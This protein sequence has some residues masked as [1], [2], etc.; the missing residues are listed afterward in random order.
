MEPDP[1]LRT[2]QPVTPAPEIEKALL[3]AVSAM[4]GHFRYESGHHGDLWLNLDELFLD[5]RSMRSWVSA[6]AQQAI[7]CRPQFVCGP[8]TGGAF[9][10]QLMAADLAAGFIFAERQVSEIGQVRYH[11]PEPLRESLRG[12]SLLLVDDAINA[13]SA[14][15][16]TLADLLACGSELVG[17]ASLFTLGEA[18]ASIASQNGVPLFTLVSLVRGMWLPPEC[19]LCRSGVPLKNRLAPS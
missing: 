2:Q 14:I 18:A 4:R 11:I 10:A 8:L 7:V 13:G 9:V 6:L 1:G 19:P 17:L 15:Q 16:A 5:A 12:R 3:K